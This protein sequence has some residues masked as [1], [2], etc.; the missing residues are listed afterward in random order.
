MTQIT[1]ASPSTV[2]QYETQQDFE[3]T[4]I[5]IY[6]ESLAP[7]NFER[8]K[9]TIKTTSNPMVE[10]YLGDLISG[11]YCSRIF[12]DCDR[13][14]CRLQSPNFPGLYPRNLTCYYAVS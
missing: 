2:A 12:S 8:I 13:K 4:S 10:Q 7:E 3:N 9:P 5:T 6:G 11:T 14:K 1:T